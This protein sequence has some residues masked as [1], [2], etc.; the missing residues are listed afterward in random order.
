MGDVLERRGVAMMSW[1]FTT[2]KG[3]LKL[4]LMCALGRSIVLSLSGWSYT[5][6]RM[7]ILHVTV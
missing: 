1:C 5:L 7:A 2:Q 3:V 4:V 6:G